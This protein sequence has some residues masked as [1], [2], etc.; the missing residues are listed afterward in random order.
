MA[1]EAASSSRR[2]RR[3]EIREGGG[4]GRLRPAVKSALS[5]RMR[6]RGKP[7]PSQRPMGHRGKVVAPHA[8]AQQRCPAAPLDLA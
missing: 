4:G 7:E 2:S 1:R 8:A 6:W 5:R 3:K